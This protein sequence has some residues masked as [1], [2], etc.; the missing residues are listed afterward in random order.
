MSN[1]EI[2]AACGYVSKEECK[3]HMQ[4]VQVSIE[5]HEERLNSKD[6]EDAKIDTKLGIHTWLL[7]GIFGITFLSFLANL[8]QDFMK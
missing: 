3:L 6:V 7:G 8:V 2:C 5:K 4:E 1:T